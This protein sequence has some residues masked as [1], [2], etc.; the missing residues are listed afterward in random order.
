MRLKTEENMMERKMTCRGFIDY[1]TFFQS[2]CHEVQ[3]EV[4]RWSS[5]R[6][7]TECDNV[8][9]ALR[10]GLT[11]KDLNLGFGDCTRR[12]MDSLTRSRW[13]KG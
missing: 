13:N 4:E 3:W 8:M 9:R 11:E 1:G 5:V 2:I 12:N 10:E 7:K 6:G